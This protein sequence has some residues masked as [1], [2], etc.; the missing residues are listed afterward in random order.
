M[1][2]NNKSWSLVVFKI[3]LVGKNIKNKICDQEGIYQKGHNYSDLC[4]S[5]IFQEQWNYLIRSLKLK[6][7]GRVAKLLQKCLN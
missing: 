2:V 3:L 4:N 7:E 5:A 1:H 6:N